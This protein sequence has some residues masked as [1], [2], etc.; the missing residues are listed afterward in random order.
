MVNLKQIRQDFPIFKKKFK[1]KPLVYFDNAS[2]TFKPLSVIKAM[3]RYY[4]EYP[5]N[6]GRGEYDLAHYLETEIESSRKKV[7]DFINAKPQEIVFTTGTTMGINLIAQSYAMHLLKPGDEIII[8]ESEHA[9]NVLPWYQVAEKTGAKVVIIDLDAQQRLTP[10][11]LK[12]H[13]NKNTK[14]VSFASI[15]NVLGTQT[16]VQ[17]LAKLAHTVGAIVIVDGA[18]SVPHR[19]TDVQMQDIDFLVFSGHK[20]LG[21][22]GIGVLYGKFQ[23]LE[24]MKPFF[25]GGAMSLRFNKD[26]KV[27]YAPIPHVFEAGTQNW[28]GIIGLK[29]A[30]EYLEKVSFELIH[31]QE[32]KLKDY[33]LAGLKKIDHIKVYNP[34]TDSAI[35]AFNIVGVNPQ[36]AATYFNSQGVAVRSGQHCAR[37]LV[38][39]L[40]TDGT[41]R[42]SA[43]FY[44]TIE[45]V[46]RFL[47]AAKKGRNFLDAYF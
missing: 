43:Y 8:T 31:S 10:D 4:L 28:S 46:D 14:I 36:D 3:D 1:G 20:M 6:A 5:V 45:E 2:T 18:Q 42:W 15:S 21:P 7:A 37:N 19:A 35:L 22:T 9:A 47:D 38:D 32:K 24:K 29:A 16:N 17:A 25:T 11:L 40:K 34:E 44:N 12:I 41:V 23:L 13:L 30:I 39:F 33:C 27:K 26:H